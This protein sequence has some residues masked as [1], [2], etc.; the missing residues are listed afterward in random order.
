MEKCITCVFLCKFVSGS[1]VPT[2]KFFEMDADDRRTGGVFQH[3]I[4]TM[5][6]PGYAHPA[7]FRMVES[8][9]AELEHIADKPDK[10]LEIATRER[11]CSKWALYEVGFS[12]M[13]HLQ[14]WRMNELEFKRQKFENDMNRSNRNF[15]IFLTGVVLVFALAE[16]FIPAAFPN[17]WPWLMRI[18]G[19]QPA[20]P[21][22]PPTPGV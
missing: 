13:D 16:I 11:E 12:P 1:H 2:P 3:T 17:G 9:R 4:N 14:D 15:Q 19:S 22:I 7:C 5:R 21:T 20:P 18:F 10:F 6:G 8:V